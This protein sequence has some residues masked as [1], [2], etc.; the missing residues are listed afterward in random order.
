M[1]CT[2]PTQ[3]YY[4]NLAYPCGKCIACQKQRAGEWATRLVHE[5]EFWPFSAFVTLT[6][7]DQYLPAEG[8]SKKHLQNF[9]KRVRNDGNNIRYFAAGEYG[10]K[11]HRAHYH[12]IIF[13][14]KPDI[15]KI[16]NYWDFGSVH[17]GTLTPE[18]VRYTTNYIIKIGG[19]AGAPLPPVPPPG[20]GLRALTPPFSLKSQGLGLRWAENNIQDILETQ[21]LRQ[22]GRKTSVPRYYCKKLDLKL[23]DGQNSR[24]EE[25][26]QSEIKWQ[27]RSGRHDMLR[28][29]ISSRRNKKAH[30]QVI[31]ER[32]NQEK[33]L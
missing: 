17:V 24:N 18:S 28:Q 23:T 3:D 15:Q 29:V 25:Y 14:L 19:G 30:Q 26:D 33:L 12:L 9:I 20:Q 6:Y 31:V 10:S 27:E 16:Q 13:G 22:Q 1:Q 8:L 32:N 5:S 4:G 2:N 21:G 7:T 11:T